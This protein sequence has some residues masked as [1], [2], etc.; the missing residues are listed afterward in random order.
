MEQ[1]DPRNMKQKNAATP[2]PLGDQRGEYLMKKRGERISRRYTPVSQ[3]PGHARH[4]A[5][6]DPDCQRHV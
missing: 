6:Q 2:M 1:L 5:F 4:E 3:F